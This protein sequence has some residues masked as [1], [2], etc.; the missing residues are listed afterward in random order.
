[1]SSNMNDLIVQPPLPL[2]ENLVV[3]ELIERTRLRNSTV[4]VEIGGTAG[5]SWSERIGVAS[6]HSVDPRNVQG[7]TEAMT[8][9]RAYGEAIPLPDNS[10]DVVFS[11]NAFQFVDFPAVLDE[12]Y[13]VLRPGGIVYAHFGPIWSGPDGH[14]LEYVSYQGRELQFWR[15][16]LLPPY[17]HLR[18]TASELRLILLTALPEPLVDKLVW[19]IHVS[20]TV[21]RLFAEDYLDYIRATR[22]AVCE[23]VTSRHLDY[24]ID[25][26]PY[27]HPLLDAATDL[28]ELGQRTR[29]RM[30]ASH[31]LGARDIRLLVQKSAG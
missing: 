15:D 24:S 6:W 28:C 11:C 21:N 10:A 22:F 8:T 17:A 25:T 29:C 14:Q 31:N 1:M 18:F 12:A 27:K 3:E 19:H 4:V 30:H 23:F 20:H 9:W 7:K 16:T 5:A 26:P 13:R 2:N